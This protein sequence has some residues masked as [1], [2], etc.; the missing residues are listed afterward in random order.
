MAQYDS[1]DSYFWEP[2]GK[3]LRNL[4]GEHDADE[5]ARKEY[6]ETAAQQFDIERG[7]IDIARTYDAGHLRTLHYELFKNVYEWAGEYRTVGMKKGPTAFAHPDAIDL[8]MSEAAESIRS[9]S[10]QSLDRDGFAQA[11]AETFSFANQAHPF[12]EGNG[13]AT[14][15]F[16]QQVAEMSPW[17]ID[18]TPKLSGMTESA[19]RLASLQVRPAEGTYDPRPGRIVPVFHAMAQPREEP[20]TAEPSSAQKVIELTRQRR[21]E[22]EAQREQRRTE[23]R[24]EPPGL[25]QGRGGPQL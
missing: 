14:K 25:Q 20:P 11:A 6:A 23:R 21:A 12:R 15:L 18:Y 10:W 2:D 7:R 19:W 8:Y 5:L 22:A 3:V 4:Y 13:R 9:F 17:R 16:M 24:R 1:W